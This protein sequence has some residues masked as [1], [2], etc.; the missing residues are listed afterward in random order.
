MKC[1]RCPGV[2]LECTSAVLCLK[3]VEGMQAYN[4]QCYYMKKYKKTSISLPSDQKCADIAFIKSRSGVVQLS[5]I[6]VGPHTHIAFA[7]TIF[8]D[9]SEWDSTAELHLE[10]NGKEVHR[11]DRNELKTFTTG[12]C[13]YFSSKVFENEKLFTT[14][15]ENN[16]EKLQLRFET[17]HK[18]KT[19]N[20]GL[21]A[22]G[23]HYLQYQCTPNCVKCIKDTHECK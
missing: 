5:P 16:I 8:Y 3:C 21:D 6:D 9:P 7:F 20:F 10:I 14:Y 1:E 19:L 15:H 2:C 18:G 17:T 13:D 4:G 22:H 23:L 12:Q 11:F